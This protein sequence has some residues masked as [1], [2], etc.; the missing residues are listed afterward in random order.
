MNML[1][2]LAPHAVILIGNMYY[3]FWGIDRVNNSMNFIDNP[4]TKFLL[5]VMIACTGFNNLRLLRLH[6]SRLRREINLTPV[7][8]RLGVL[9]VNT[10]LAAVILVL[11]VID[12][13]NENLML[14]LNEFVKALILLLSIT[15]LL[16]SLQ[17]TKRARDAV[18]Y[19]MRHRAQMRRPQRRPAPQPQ[20][21]PQTR[22]GSAR[23]PQPRYDYDDRPPQPRSYDGSRPRPRSGRYDDFRPQPMRDNG[24]NRR[25]QPRYDSRY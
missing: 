19:E 4:Y 9:A 17:L 20:R 5:L 12:L 1:M 3:V 14:F 10:L 16:N 18:R 22:Y 2:K 7:F 21:A 23:P 25:S 11:L 13:F 8:V 15:G 6:L 24:V